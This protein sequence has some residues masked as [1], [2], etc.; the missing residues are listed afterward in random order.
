MQF[1]NRQNLELLIEED[2]RNFIFLSNTTV[3]EKH[4]VSR[5]G[6]KIIRI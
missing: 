6:K 5:F 3:P 4:S 1:Y 2:F